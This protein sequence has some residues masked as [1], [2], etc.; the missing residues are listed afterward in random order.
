MELAFGLFSCQFCCSFEC[1]GCQHIVQFHLMTFLCGTKF[2]SYSWLEIGYCRKKWKVHLH[3]NSNIFHY[4]AA[5]ICKIKFVDI[6]LFNEAPPTFD[7]RLQGAE[8]SDKCTFT[9]ILIYF[10]CCCQS[11]VK[12]HLTT[13]P[14]STKFPPLLIGDWRRQKKREKC[15]FSFIS[16]MLLSI[17]CKI[18]F[19]DISLWNEVPP[20][21][22]DWRLQEA[23]KKWKVHF[24]KRSQSAIADW[25]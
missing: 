20:L 17:I 5:I 18:L 22:L 14:F 8:K 3:Y 6:S 24:H 21:T 4:A 19:D 13:F 1:C 23:E 10:L 11:F 25:Q 9:L 16:F 15:T 2:P 7:W 12:F